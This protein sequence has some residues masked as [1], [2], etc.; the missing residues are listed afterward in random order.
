MITCQG[1]KKRSSDHGHSQPT[2]F[3]PVVTESSRLC[4]SSDT[5]KNSQQRTSP[6]LNHRRPINTQSNGTTKAN[7]REGVKP[8]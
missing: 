4:D 8:R 5:V 2:P 3:P 1:A 7:S 6:A